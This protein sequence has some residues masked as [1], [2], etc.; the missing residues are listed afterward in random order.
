[1]SGWDRMPNGN[2]IFVKAQNKQII[3]VTPSGEVILDYRIPDNGRMYRAYKYP[4][5]YPGL[6]E[7]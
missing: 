2:T 7:F 5:N 4:E 1:M 3:E 6:G